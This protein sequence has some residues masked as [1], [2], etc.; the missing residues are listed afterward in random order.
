MKLNTIMYD[1][2]FQIK[3]YAKS[4]NQQGSI[5]SVETR[6]VSLCYYII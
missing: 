5:Q 6:N 4:S 3:L 2:M 1:E